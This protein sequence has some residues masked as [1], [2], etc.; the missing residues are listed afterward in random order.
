MTNRLLSLLFAASVTCLAL[1]LSLQRKTARPYGE[2]DA[3]EPV[4]VPEVNVP[5]FSFSKN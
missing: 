3:G 1:V 5:G 4:A 2:K